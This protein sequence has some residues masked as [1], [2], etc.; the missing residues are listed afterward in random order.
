[1]ER[2]NT[3]K[4]EIPSTSF[5]QQGSSISD[6]T[7]RDEVILVAERYASELISLKKKEAAIHIDEIAS[8]V[9]KF[10]EKVRKIIDW[11]DD[12]A[13]RRG[14]IERILKRILFPK[15]VGFSSKGHDTKE[16]AQ[17]ITEELVRGGH[18]PNHEIPQ[19][20][21]N[22]A[23]IALQKYLFFLEHVYSSSGV[24]DVKKKND[25][26]MFIIEIAACE[27]EEILTRPVKEVF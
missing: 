26:S 5:V 16:L 10:Y 21:V 6:A 15:M 20:R 13:L 17:T 3:I 12:N 14:A 9:A 22:I 27:M 19:S 7:L 8:G 25:L 18:L 2:V 1:M 11:K 23:S 24:I 4:Q